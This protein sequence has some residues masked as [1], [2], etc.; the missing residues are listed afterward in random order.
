M[1]RLSF[2]NTGSY[3]ALEAAIHAAR[4]AI[5]L[6]ICQG[7]NVL[8]IACGE[9]YGSA[10]LRRW[11]A[12]TVDGIDISEAAI[13]SA[14]EKFHDSRVNF[15]VGRAEEAQTSFP[16]KRFDLI[17][18]LETFEHLDDPS[19]YLS[20]IKAL[21]TETAI[22][23]I[24][25]PNDHWYYPSPAQMNP[26]HKRKYTFKEYRDICE[27]ILGP[28]NWRFGSLAIGFMT[29]EQYPEGYE[30]G[31]QIA[32]MNHKIVS[33]TV[34]VPPN[35]QT[36]PTPDFASYFV[37]VWGAQELP[38]S[39]AV[40]PSSMKSLDAGPF[41]GGPQDVLVEEIDQLR[42]DVRRSEMSRKALAAENSLLRE[43]TLQASESISKLEAENESLKSALQNVPWRAV[44]TYLA[45][46][47][48]IPPSA[49]RLFAKYIDRVR[50]RRK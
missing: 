15:T 10:L 16:D 7:R 38:T 33:D 43:A 40:F 36:A 35:A 42:R 49:L 18:S 20:Q 11:G 25:C 23:I 24:S 28:A 34:M 32:M 31:N 44:G 2:D 30:P 12:S 13:R 1:E 41:S 9:G 39:G 14:R 22:I 8:D 29:T 5:A 50:I 48:R 27:S 19:V 37:G 26:F 45:V 4:Y 47:H 3:S 46:R 17:I 6:P 21:A